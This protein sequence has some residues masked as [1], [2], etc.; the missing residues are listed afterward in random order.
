M[1]PRISLAAWRF[2][3]AGTFNQQHHLGQDLTGAL[4]GDFFSAPT[5]QVN[6]G[7]VN[8]GNASLGATITDY[9][10]L[11]ASDYRVQFDGSNYTF[12]RL[13]ATRLRRLRRC[14]TPS[15]VYS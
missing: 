1:R 7:T 12:T 9:T 8:T 11:A 10:Q 4:G 2:N 3:L 14:R 6:Q 15:T 13:S 5:P